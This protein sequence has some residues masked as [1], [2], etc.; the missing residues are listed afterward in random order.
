[1]GEKL[2][3]QKCDRTFQFSRGLG[4]HMATIHRDKPKITIQPIKKNNDSISIVVANIEQENRELQR[5]AD[6]QRAA[7]KRIRDALASW[8]K[9][10]NIAKMR[11]IRRA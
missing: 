5:L 3:C 7:L 8:E 9:E 2:K 1:M 6:V 4:R 11:D 10:E